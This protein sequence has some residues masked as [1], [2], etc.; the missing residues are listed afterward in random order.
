M[1][2]QSVA[3][4][5]KQILDLI[6]ASFPEREYTYGQAL[7]KF[8]EGF[9]PDEEALLT[10]SGAMTEHEQAV[11]GVMLFMQVLSPGKVAYG[12]EVLEEIE[13]LAALEPSVGGTE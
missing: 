8:F 2:V 9:D 7:E 11:L 13:R 12:P 5:V 4:D 6:R 3:S 1:T 10:T